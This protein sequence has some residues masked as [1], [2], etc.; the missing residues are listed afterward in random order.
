[1][2]TGSRT[3]GLKG[4]GSEGFIRTV[5]NLTV[6]G[7]LV[8]YGET[9]STVGT[10]HDVSAFWETADANAN[11]WAYDLPS[12][13]ATAVP[14]MGVGIGLK[15]V[16]LGLFDGITQ[17]TLAVLDAD[18]DSYLVLDFSAD[19]S[20]R[21]RSNQDITVSG[22]V[23]FSDN[24]TV[25]G[26][27]TTVSSSTVVIDDPLFH[28]GNDNNAD[29]VDLG[30]FA[31]YTDSGKKFAGLFRDA[32]D[33]DK[34][35][36]FATTGNSHEEPSTTVNTTSG[37]TLANLAVNELEGTLATA[38]QTNI[39]AVGTIATGTWEGTTIAVDQGGTGAT[40]LNNLITLTTHTT[41][42]YVATVTAGTGLTSTGATSGEGIAH[43]LSV[44]A[45][46]TGI[47]SVGALDGGSIT[48]NFGTID[49]GASSITTTG[50]ISGGSLDIDNVEINGNTISTSTSS[51][52]LDPTTELTFTLTADTNNALSMAD[53]TTTL[54]AI[55]SRT[56]T[57]GTYV[58]GLDS[59][60][61]TL[62]DASS[63]VHQLIEYKAYNVTLAGTTQVT[64]S[65]RTMNIEQTNILQ[66]GGAVTVDQ[67]IT[68]RIAG[69]PS[70]GGSVTITE[71]LALLVDA[72]ASRFDGAIS[73]TGDLT[74]DGDLDFTGAQEISTSAGALTIA[75]ATDTLF[76]NGTGVV[77]G[78]TAQVS[79]NDSVNAG[80]VTSELQVLGS[81]WGGDESITIGGFNTNAVRAPS[82]LFLRSKNG[83]V[84][85]NTAVA[86]DDLLGGIGWNG[87]NGTN[88][89]TLAA[90]ITAEVDTGTVSTSSMPG[91]LVFKTSA[92]GSEVPAVKMVW[93]ATANLLFAQASTI[94]P[95]ASAHNAVGYALTISSG[96]TTAG[97]T[98]NIAGG[99]LTIQGGQGKGS[100]AGGDIIFQTANAGSSGSSI[101]ALAT[102]LTISDDLSS[103]FAGAV[104]IDGDMVFTGPQQISASSGTLTIKSA[105]DTD[106]L[107][108]SDGV[109]MSLT[110][111]AVAGW[112]HYIGNTAL[113]S[114]VAGT[115]SLE[116]RP[117]V[118]NVEFAIL[119][120][121]TT[122]AKFVVNS[123]LGNTQIGGT[124]D[125][126]TTVGT[127]L[128]S[129]F[130]GTAPVGT[131]ANGISMYATSGE[132]RVMDAA[133]IA[134]RF[135]GGTIN[136]STGDLTLDPAGGDVNLTNNNLLNVGAAGNDW[137]TN[138]LKVETSNDGGGNSIEVRNT[139]DTSASSSFLYIAVAGSSSG[140]P[141]I[142][143]DEQGGH[144]M[145]IG[146][147][148]SASHFVWAASPNPGTNDAIRITDAEPPVLSLNTSQGSDFDYVCEV[149]GRHEA[150][151]F[152]C[153]G[154]VEWHDDTM[155][156]VPVLR[157]MTAEKMTHQHPGLQHL[158]K[159]GVFELT[160][161]NDGAEEV[162]LAMQPA[163]WYTWSMID[164]T[165]KMLDAQYEELSRRLDKLGV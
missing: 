111:N 75:P 103:T 77:I 136:T 152:V 115:G 7:D 95:N 147:D 128:L 120:A 134:M 122:N 112:E 52:T 131:L 135:S 94:H 85:G 105:D 17:P 90:T 26:T 65:Q 148:V 96:D 100:G 59:P 62:A 64:T 141:K 97:T 13:G 18:Q 66:S 102:A 80:A 127:N 25:N 155:A 58:F 124:A 2:T 24:I 132:F 160:H 44:D 89:H 79:V 92:D 38:S 140:D 129:I 164:Q 68:L 101:N 28:L 162:F 81:T 9:R 109:V 61:V 98:D 87:A 53:G 93:D 15:D 149:C 67:A 4:I 49:T 145:S 33:S 57:A 137:T 35:K 32:S 110:R 20:P 21:I 151:I 39:T 71:P 82:L 37:F 158:A 8:V 76:S 99:A 119:Q 6:T 30:I 142:Y 88:F 27:T 104:T 125:H 74:V 139:S 144:D 48:S 12:G 51:L 54:F 63:A 165:R 22:N 83:T 10:G 121:G 118:G 56:T 3:E 133:G 55:D 16:D 46:Q 107:R 84:G 114:G 40:S 31:E 126:G 34:W 123:T 43:G 69:A 1:M 29:A 36:L 5:K 23:V 163:Q 159:L 154:K 157:A 45:A 50:L 108:A 72:G 86:T 106:I 130:D 146:V 143:I 70:A 138:Q 73:M 47:T 42:N 153:C 113:G 156:I 11:Y 117:N 150:Q 19:D 41:G 91:R 60:N 116:L 161:D 14:V 78:H